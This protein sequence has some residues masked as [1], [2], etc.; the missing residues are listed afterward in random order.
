[1]PFPSGT[2]YDDY[3]TAIEWLL[4]S[5]DDA[6]RYPILKVKARPR[7]TSALAENFASWVRYAPSQEIPSVVLG[8]H[9]WLRHRGDPKQ[10]LDRIEGALTFNAGNTQELGNLTGNLFHP[11]RSSDSVIQCLTTM[12][13]KHRAGA[14]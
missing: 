10:F 3:R 2:M 6:A 8:V 11:I 1:M 4:D 7:L 14:R 9:R 13:L 5:L 12:S